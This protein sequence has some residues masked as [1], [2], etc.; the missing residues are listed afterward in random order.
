M[1]ATYG[2]KTTTSPASGT[3]AN[4]ARAS[5]FQAM[6][7]NG[8]GY[9]WGMHA[10]R[11]TATISNVRGHIWRVASNVP[12]A[13]VAYTNPIAVNNPMGSGTDTGE[14]SGPTTAVF[15]LTAGQLYAIGAVA[16]DGTLLHGM[17]ATGLPVGADNKFYTRAVT[18]LDPLDPMAHTGTI[19]A[20]WM[21][22]WVDYT[23][24]VAPNVPNF[25]AP[26]GPI[27]GQ[28]AV[29]TGQF[30]DTNQT[31][32]GTANP[33][34]KLNQYRIQLREVGGSTL[35]WDA[36]YSAGSS[37]KA[38]GAFQVGYLGSGTLDPGIAYEWRCAVSDTHGEWS[39]WSGWLSF[40]IL[41]AGAA[42]P[43]DPPG[44]AGKQDVQRPQPYRVTYTHQN[45][46]NA[47]Q[48]Q[49]QIL[50]A[51]GAVLRDVTQPGTYTPNQTYE[52][53]L[54]PSGVVDLPW[55]AS[56]SWRARFRD[57]ASEWSGW[58]NPVAFST[59]TA[60]SVPGSLSPAG[61]VVVSGFADLSF[62]FTDPDDTPATG[63]TAQV[64]IKN[65]TGTVLQ[66][67]TA[68]LGSDGRWHYQT[69]AADLPATGS[70]RWDARSD[71]GTLISSWSSEADFFYAE[72]PTI[73]APVVDAV[74][75]STT[76]AV[77]YS[78]TGQVR[79]HFLI[80]PRGS[81]TPAL[82]TSWATTGSTGTVNVDMAAFVQ[83]GALYDL[84]VEVELSGS[85]ISRSVRVP[86]EVLLNA[87]H[88]VTVDTGQSGPI[89]IGA[90]P[91]DSA[92]RMVAASSTGVTAGNFVAWR[93]KEGP[94]DWAAR[95]ASLLANPPSD[96]NAALRAKAA[97]ARELT[98]VGEFASFSTNSFV[99]FEP[100]LA[101]TMSYTL[102]AVVKTGLNIVESLPV[103]GI[104]AVC[105]TA[106]IVLHD[107]QDP[108]GRR[109]HL[110]SLDE[111][112]VEEVRNQ[113]EY[114]TWSDGPPAILE[115]GLEYLVFSDQYVLLPSH[116]E[117]VTVT[118]EKL[119]A[120]RRF[121]ADDSP[122]VC[123]RRDDLGQRH[124][125]RITGLKAGRKRGQQ[126]D[127]QVEMTEVRR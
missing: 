3:I 39:A 47:G 75:T 23:P 7:E 64:R 21:T 119:R 96:P 118:F 58:S 16:R 50:S 4:S 86:F 105:D 27:E 42:Y 102:T 113:S 70:Y 85:V 110:L 10:G 120:L 77:T 65:S 32:N 48:L 73:T 69:I 122:I 98:T 116:G 124:D 104:A 108:T 72:Q 12:G 62:A 67:R 15:P 80:Y 109:V 111:E 34:E 55:G 24:N 60:P 35:F 100:R 121:R 22:T 59:N 117:D 45:S 78:V 9:A 28:P 114:E 37:E 20:G 95:W 74:V 40:T 38:A 11:S 41:A 83:N 25:R 126:L 46:L 92:I 44:V 56:Y 51:T 107:V 36:T 115:S 79:R 8:W 84:V 93:I 94:A 63:L 101:R 33:L 19:V 88:G 99:Y 54:W 18:N 29:F 30:H 106:M 43:A 123:C 61:G 103:N 66:T 53:N 76:L 87:G 71:D 17:I 89:R 52:V 127:V 26:S 125:V 5:I 82:N 81:T 14:V 6:P 2:R 97:L 68:T 57:S 13:L 49:L 1:C 112:S 31:V 91:E 90:E